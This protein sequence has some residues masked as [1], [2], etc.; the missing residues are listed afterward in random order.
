MVLLRHPLFQ[1]LCALFVAFV[2]TGD[3]VGDAIHDA[4]GACAT[5]SQD[6]GHDSCPACAQCSFHTG[7]ALAHRAIAFLSFDA[8][9]SD[10][11]LPIDDQLALGAAP[12]IDHPPQLA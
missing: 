7:A 10:L 8:S 1:T 6:A 5:E 4:S 2:I 12:S 3:I 11:A 9:A